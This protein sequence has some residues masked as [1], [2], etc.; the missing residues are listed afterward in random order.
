[1]GKNTECLQQIMIKSM[2]SVEHLN[3]TVHTGF[4]QLN[5]LKLAQ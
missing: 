4:N 1:M 2:V 5:S 3:F